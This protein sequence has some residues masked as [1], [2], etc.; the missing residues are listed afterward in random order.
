VVTL[1]DGTKYE[2]DTVCINSLVEEDGELKILECKDFADS[3]K[4]AAFYAGIAKFAAQG[5][6][7]S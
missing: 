6:P 2:Y 1:I 3:H 5:K 7:A 4:R